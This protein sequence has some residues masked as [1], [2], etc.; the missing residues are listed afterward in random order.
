MLPVDTP[1]LQLRPLRDYHAGEAVAWRENASSPMLYG[2]V[3][4]AVGYQC[5]AG[6]MI[7]TSHAATEPSAS[8]AAPGLAQFQRIEVRV[9]SHG[10]IKSMLSTAVFSFR[11]N[12]GRGATA[13]GIGL[14][15][16]ARRDLLPPTAR[17]ALDS[18]AAAA[19]AAS[20][21]AANGSQVLIAGEGLPVAA[22][23][24][25]GAVRD[26]LTMLDVPLSLDQEQLLEANLDLQEKLRQARQQTA[27]LQ[28]REKEL[29]RSYERMKDAFTCQICMARDAQ[30]A[31]VACGHRY[32]QE[33]MARMHASGGARP[34]CAYCRQQY[35]D[36]IPFF[37]PD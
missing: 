2:T 27:A 14:P 25:T 35:S 34:K 33:C 16:D 11:S 30:V 19:A 12:R 15:Q 9:D 20:T 29:T 23:E 22:S 7:S 13:A 37:T 28:T 21:A 17:A 5:S 8:A 32:C 10:T 4:S 36:T 18:P 26:L 31:L 3:V 6:A 1:L 24:V